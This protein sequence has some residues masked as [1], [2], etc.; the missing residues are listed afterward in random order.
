ME[1]IAVNYV[2]ITIHLTSV[3]FNDFIFVNRYA[4]ANTALLWTFPCIP[5]STVTCNARP[6]NVC[7]GRSGHRDDVVKS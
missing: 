6:K 3:S 2:L 5:I 7:L 4:P 1:N